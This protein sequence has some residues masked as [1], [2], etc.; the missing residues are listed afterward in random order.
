MDV[1][2]SFAAVG[3]LLGDPARANILNALMDGRAR[4]AT[5]LAFHTAVSVPTA[6][7]HLAKLTEAGARALDRLL[8]GASLR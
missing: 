3:A 1:E 8:P 6:S 2:P 5:E 4:T 7:G